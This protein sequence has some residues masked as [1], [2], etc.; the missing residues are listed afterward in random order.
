MKHSITT[1]D[2][3]E[4][5]LIGLGRPDR[6]PLLVLHGASAS[7][8]TFQ[9]P[10]GLSFVD[11]AA[12]HFDLWL[13]DW[14]GSG[15]LST[16]LVTTH[17]DRDSVFTFDRVAYFDNPAA[18]DYIATQRP[19]TPI[20]VFAHCAGA[21]AFARTIELNHPSIQYVD[22]VVLQTLGLFWS[23]PFDGRLKAQDHILEAVKADRLMSGEMLLIDPAVTAWPPLME[24]SFELWKRAPLRHGCALEF[25]DRIAFMYGLPYIP[26]NLHPSMHTAAELSRQFGRM[27][28]TMYI[29]G[30]QNIRRGFAGPYRLDRESPPVQQPDRTG[31]PLDHRPFRK[32][33]L[34]LLTGALNTVWHR[35]SIDR[36]HAWLLDRNGPKGLKKVVVPDFGHQ[37][38]LWGGQKSQPIFAQ[39]LE[40]LH[41]RR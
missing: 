31:A 13:L 21:A 1:A 6:P 29:H 26:E 36:M 3:L 30:T 25:C 10:A 34:T 19:K 2:G 17:R 18:L 5:Q 23:T 14:R 32:M 27:P 16:E 20:K 7:S 15:L 39:V 4:L 24:R 33:S 22:A 38:L 37:D 41:A 40:A 35:D 9:S 8:L 11:Y 28:L 12:P